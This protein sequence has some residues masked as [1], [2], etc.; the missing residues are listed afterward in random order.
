M[1]CWTGWLQID[2]SR[3]EVSGGG[4]KSVLPCFERALRRREQGNARR[5]SP[6]WVHSNRLPELRANMVAFTPRVRQGRRRGALVRCAV[7]P[8]LED[9]EPMLQERS[10]AFHLGSLFYRPASRITRDL[11]VL[12]LAVLS[13]RNSAIGEPP[14]AYCFTRPFGKRHGSLAGTSPQPE[15]AVHMPTPPP[16]LR[17]A[18]AG[19]HERLGCACVA[20][21]L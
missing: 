17:P 3:C 9:D 4:V 12:A 15:C 2:D 5:H 6:R 7:H 14:G 20:L 8:A 1:G 10:A 11:G 19:C 18:R 21:L 13:S 16:H